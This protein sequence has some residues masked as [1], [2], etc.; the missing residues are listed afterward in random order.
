MRQRRVQIRVDI[1]PIVRSQRDLQSIDRGEGDARI[2]LVAGRKAVDLKLPGD[3][4]GVRRSVE[5]PAGSAELAIASK[6]PLSTIAI[7]VIRPFFRQSLLQ[8]P[9][10]NL[11]ILEETRPGDVTRALRGHLETRSDE[12]AGELG[13]A[14]SATT[15][16]LA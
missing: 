10:R 16:F 15:R 14:G 2:A 8:I 4:D 13:N 7:D 6:G 12:L 3:V 5:E 9:P 1:T 11:R